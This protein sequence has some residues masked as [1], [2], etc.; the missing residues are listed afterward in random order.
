MGARSLLKGPFV[1]FKLLKKVNEA[2]KSNIYKVINTWSRRSTILP[3]FVGR[4]IA[5]HNGKI[6]VP[7]SIG[8][9][10]VGKK[11]GEFA[12]TRKFKGHSNNRK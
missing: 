8:E 9:Q 2:N 10:M 12:P 4:V 5:V 11:L 7:V 3:S 1:N 6:M